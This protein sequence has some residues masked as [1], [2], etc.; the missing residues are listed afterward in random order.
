MGGKRG[1]IPASNIARET[2]EYLA[3]PYHQTYGD[4]DIYKLNEPSPYYYEA[5]A[6]SLAVLQPP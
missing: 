2:E 6:L 1:H 5:F 3:L 4:V